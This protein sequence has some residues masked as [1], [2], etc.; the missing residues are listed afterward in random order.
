MEF[1]QRDIGFVPVTEVA[2]TNTFSAVRR[3]AGREV[4]AAAAGGI[5]QGLGPPASNKCLLC[6]TPMQRMELHQT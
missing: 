6:V 3:G 4:A 5:I 2:E 1:K